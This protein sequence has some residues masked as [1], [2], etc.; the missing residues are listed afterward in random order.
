MKVAVDLDNT[1]DAE[2]P[3][4]QSL[5]SALR[6]AGHVV[7]VV[8][9]TAQ[10]VASQN[11]WNAKAD[12]LSKLGCGACYDTLVVIASPDGSSA[13]LKAKW[14]DENGVDILIDNSK[15]NAKAAVAV[16]IPLV[17]VPWASR[18]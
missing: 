13:D 4:L 14:C 15:E 2:P 17:L 16:G 3:R 10:D 6:A 1:I 11:E 5:L 18:F 7:V 8:T 9:G 12:Y